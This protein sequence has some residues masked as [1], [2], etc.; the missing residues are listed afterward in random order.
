MR[1][2]RARAVVGVGSLLT[3]G[4]GSTIG[5]VSASASNLTCAAQPSIVQ[6]APAV[7]GSATVTAT[8]LGSYVVKRTSTTTL[9]VSGTPVANTGW[10]AGVPVASGSRV[11]VVYHSTTSSQLARY[12]SSLTSTG[13]KLVTH[14]V[15]CS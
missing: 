1:A 6:T 13:A 14:V 10:A 9:A 4:M 2:P 12:T 3:L 5:A 15:K 11:R 7:N 8:G